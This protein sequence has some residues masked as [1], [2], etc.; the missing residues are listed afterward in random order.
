MAV[1]SAMVRGDRY[2]VEAEGEGDGPRREV[3]Q[4]E[5]IEERGEPPRRLDADARLL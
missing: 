4:S 1:K 2:E 5:G 3:R